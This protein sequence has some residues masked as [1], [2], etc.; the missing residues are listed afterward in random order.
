MVRMPMRGRQ[1]AGMRWSRGD[2]AAVGL[3]VAL[4]TL[5]ALVPLGFAAT[6][7]VSVL[8]RGRLL[9]WIEL[10]VESLEVWDRFTIYRTPETSIGFDEVNGLLLATL[11]G[12]AFLVSVVLDRRPRTA[13]P[14]VRWFFL[15]SWLGAAFFAVDE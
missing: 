15:I 4:L 8:A 10:E 6:Q 12:M 3:R 14:R 2:S 5:A 11:S 7:G 9:D 1:S 13:P